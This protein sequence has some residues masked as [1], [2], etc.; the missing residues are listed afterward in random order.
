MPTIPDKLNFRPS[1]STLNYWL[2]TRKGSTN[3]LSDRQSRGLLSTVGYDFDSLMFVIALI[4]EI[5]GIIVLVDSGRSLGE[6]LFAQLAIIGAVALFLLDLFLAFMYHRKEGK[7]N[8]HLKKLEIIHLES[9]ELDANAKRRRKEEDVRKNRPNIFWAILIVLIAIV[10]LVTVVFLGTFTHVAFYVFFVFMFGIIAYIHIKHTGYFLAEFFLSNSLPIPF[11]RGKIYKDY[12]KWKKGE[13]DVTI[14]HNEE[15]TL[16]NSWTSSLD[17]F[18]RLAYDSDKLPAN[19]PRNHYIKKKILD[20][21]EKGNPII[22]YTLHVPQNDLLYDE[23]LRPF[24][25]SSRECNREILDQLIN[26]QLS[27]VNV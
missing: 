23:D 6:A 9:S 16:G 24:L 2:K 10:K 22:Q 25:V 21:D 3:L 7:R 27:Q 5:V 18:D 4:C 17:Y 19:H 14:N 8:Y 13:T 26:I 15:I 11:L 1:E 20:S 12:D